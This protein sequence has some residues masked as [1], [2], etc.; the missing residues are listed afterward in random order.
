MPTSFDFEAAIRQAMAAAGLDEEVAE[1]AAAEVLARLVAPDAMAAV[2]EV[3]HDVI[4]GP[5]G[6]NEHA[7]LDGIEQRLGSGDEAAL[8]A[9]AIA[10]ALDRPPTPLP[11]DQVLAGQVLALEYKDWSFDLV[12][13]AGRPAVRVTAPLENA[14]RPGE[15]FT[16][17][18]TVPIRHAAAEA[19]LQAVLWIEEHEARERLRA[20][21]RTVLSPHA[22]P[23]YPTRQVG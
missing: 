8:I 23:P 17:S 12:L 11:A 18:K 1:R 6:V 10:D 7:A 13:Q 19:A 2:A 21:G 16:R 9:A 14:Y 3:V 20:K 4:L 5:I 15:L 22:P